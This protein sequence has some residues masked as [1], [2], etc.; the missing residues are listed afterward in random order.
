MRT[1]LRFVTGLE[2]AADER[3]IL[4]LLP[5]GPGLSSQTLRSLEILRRS[6]RLAFVDPPGTGG[7]PEPESPD[8]D[9]IVRSIEAELSGLGSK[10]P[11]LLCGHSF[12]G[13]YAA[14]LARRG[15]LK[16]AGLIIIAAPFSKGAYRVACH[17]YDKLMTPVLRSAV[18]VWEQQ[19]SRENLASLFASYEGLY[20]PPAS[21][22]AGSQMLGSD[23]VSASTF[24][25]VL[26]ALSD[27]KS[28]YRF[29]VTARNVSAPKLFIAGE[30]D[31]LFPVETLKREAQTIAASFEVVSG[32]GHFAFFDQPEAVAK[33]IEQYFIHDMKGNEQ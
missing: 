19:P 29:E 21:V 32:A 7:S 22:T 28:P 24:K 13:L 10:Q 30:L 3:P 4:C 8:F 26:P 9:S 33:Q 1:H 12:G 20:F 11:L 16:A 14:E 31:P 27:P 2:D 25:G 6:F 18:A 17:L 5:G 15:N 23:Q